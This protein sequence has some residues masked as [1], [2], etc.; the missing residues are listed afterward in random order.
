MVIIKKTHFKTHK[1]QGHGE[2]GQSQGDCR[3]SEVTRYHEQEEDGQGGEEGGEGDPRLSGPQG[4]PVDADADDFVQAE[5]GAQ[6]DRPRLPGG[7]RLLQE[8]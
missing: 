8:R 7:V 4:A 3:S 5:Q 6:D 2:E 1:L